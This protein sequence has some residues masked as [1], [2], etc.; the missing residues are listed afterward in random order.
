MNLSEIVIII[1]MGIGMGFSLMGVSTS[2]IYVPFVI[3]LFGSKFGNSIIFIPFMLSNFYISYKFRKN[4]DK[5]TV[6]KLIPFSFLGIILASICANYISEETFRIVIGVIIIL[7]SIIFFLK[8]YENSL[9][10]LGWIFGIVGGASSYLANV[11]GPIFDVYLLSF[12][13]EEKNY[14]GSRAVFYSAF[15][16]MKFLF[17]LFVF[18][19]IDFYTISRGSLAIPFILIGVFI[20]KI[21]LKHIS[22]NL[23]NKIVILLGV[24]S[25][26]QMI[27]SN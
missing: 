18:K 6:L 13:K 9:T 10:K 11:S 22:Q 3:S 23:F 20:A 14:I 7:S 1:S 12:K 4:F 27:L 19:N 24:V 21:I 2:V 15:N 17:Y 16:I 26:I 25:A 5:D 8:K